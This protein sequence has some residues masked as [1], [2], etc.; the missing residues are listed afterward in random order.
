MS[1]WMYVRNLWRLLMTT[2]KHDPNDAEQKTILGFICEK[3][4]SANAGPGTISD[5]GND[6]GGKSYG[7]WQLSLNAGTLRRYLAV[8]DFR[9]NFIEVPDGY[10][11]GI[12]IKPGSEIFDKI[13]T[14]LA[15][16]FPRRFAADQK[17]FIMKTHYYPAVRV[18]EG[19]GFTY[20]HRAIQEAI[21]SISVQHGGYATI[22]REARKL[23]TDRNINSQVTALYRARTEYVTRLQ[24]ADNIHE[25]L[26][27]R[28]VQECGD[29]LMLCDDP[30]P[31]LD[32]VQA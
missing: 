30:P 29:V 8:S 6:P 11:T 10:D 16:E 15:K 4:E 9:D 12:D 14:R 26:L 25:A 24:L 23:L 21:F 28:Y 19:H 7:S 27:S 18:A 22:I 20:T 2:I 17:I 32:L 1:V 3:Y 13:W 5:P 31:I